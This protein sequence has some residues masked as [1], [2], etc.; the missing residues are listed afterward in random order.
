MLYDYIQFLLVYFMK[1][2]C[3]FKAQNLLKRLGKKDVK[4]LHLTEYELNIASQLIIPSGKHIFI[5]L[6]Y[7]S[8]C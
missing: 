6:H 1:C 7:F 5:N 8:F 3:V 4:D 2:F